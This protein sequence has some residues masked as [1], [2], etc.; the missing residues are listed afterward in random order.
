MPLTQHG[1]DFY[2][3][4]IKKN[5]GISLTYINARCNSLIL[6]TSKE[7]NE[8][9]CFTISFGIVFC[10]VATT[11]GVGD[12]TGAQGYTGDDQDHLYKLFNK[13]F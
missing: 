5:L 7:K 9:K 2:P 11:S 10:S 1:Q 13:Q 12:G 3:N 8:K 6:I 4:P